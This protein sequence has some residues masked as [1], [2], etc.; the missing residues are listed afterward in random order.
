MLDGFIVGVPCSDRLFEGF[1]MVG[2]LKKL[3]VADHGSS[4]FELVHR[5]CDKEARVSS[6]DI[7]SYL[8]RPGAIEIHSWMRPQT[9]GKMSLYTG[10]RLKVYGPTSTPGPQRCGS[11]YGTWAFIDSPQVYSSLVCSTLMTMLRIALDFF[12]SNGVV[13]CIHS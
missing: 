4:L 9:L 10:L 1:G 5:F 12:E 6:I 13:A 3:W 7:W 8:T 11:Q 2:Y